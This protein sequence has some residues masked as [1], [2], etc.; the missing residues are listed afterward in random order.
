MARHDLS[1]PSHFKPD[2][3]GEVWKVPYQERAEEV[4][5]W[6]E[7]H[8][9]IS[10]ANDVFK[11]CLV[12]VDIQNTFCIPGFE[13]YVGGR[14]GTGA[15]DD[16]RRLCEFIYRNLDVITQICPTMDTHQAMQIFH[17]IYL[18]NDKGEHPAPF[19]LISEEDVQKG[20]WRFNPS[21]CYSFQINEEY[22]RRHLLYYT[23]KLKEG[24][25]YD[26]TIW[27]YHAM[28]GGI[29]HALV[30]SVEEAIFFHGIAR[31]SQP[32]FHIKGDKPF[33][34]HYSVLGPEVLE[35]PAGEPIAQK[36]DKFFQKLVQFDAVIIA[37][38]AK[39]HCVA[40]TIDDLLE[41]ILARDRQL[42]E[43]V[44]LLKDCTSPVV[45]PG[46]ID[47]MDQANAAFRRFADAGMHVICSTD[48]I[49]NWPGIKL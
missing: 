48:P 11:V 26:L 47:Y 42:V 33:T 37:G 12:A 25:K 27:P 13:L 21:L 35:C 24:G 10:A 39:S 6:A 18:V 17:S 28:L 29:G 19:T 44:Y 8:N 34:E 7:K 36:N 14:S 41:D 16:N 9:I 1:I 5:K 43:K 46:V 38:Q 30:A 4:R 23:K 3:V 31:Y 49:E 20:V 32:D 22:G 15:I 2:K 40:W 45:V